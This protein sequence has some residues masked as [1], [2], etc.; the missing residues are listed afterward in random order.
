MTQCD[1]VDSKSNKKNSNYRLYL[2]LKIFIVVVLY[3]KIMFND[4]T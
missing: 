3:E 4:V 1:G 2:E